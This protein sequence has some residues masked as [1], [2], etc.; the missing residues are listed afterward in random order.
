MDNEMKDLA[1]RMAADEANKG[2]YAAAAELTDFAEGRSYVGSN[3][4]LYRGDP[5]APTGPLTPGQVPCRV[6]GLD[7]RTRAATDPDDMLCTVCRANEPLRR[8]KQF[9]DALGAAAE[10]F[11]GVE[12][13]TPL[14]ETAEGSAE[15]DLRRERVDTLMRLADLVEGHPL[16]YSLVHAAET[17]FRH[18]LVP[19][20]IV[21]QWGIADRPTPDGVQ[22]GVDGPVG[23]PLRLVVES[24]ELR[25]RQ[26][27]SGVIGEPGPE[28]QMS[29]VPGHTTTVQH[30]LD[31]ALARIRE[32]EANERIRKFVAKSLDRLKPQLARRIA[33]VIC[34]PLEVSEDEVRGWSRLQID[35]WGAIQRAARE[36]AER[37][38]EKGLRFVP[39]DEEIELAAK[40]LR[41]IVAC[42]DDQSFLQE[43]D[44]SLCDRADDPELQGDLDDVRKQLNSFGRRLTGGATD[45]ANW[46]VF[47][48]VRVPDETVFGKPEADHG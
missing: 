40:H 45:P 42:T 33:A 47:G 34:P 22:F 18:V 46:G 31:S 26:D 5:D 32:L 6:C 12:P 7:D 48:L 39:T 38:V 36:A 20:Q 25:L 28:L 4:L 16:P 14:E 41:F 8:R 1:A 30:E 15:L 13:N 44:G 9:R 3:G 21:R 23:F 2:N 43:W 17:D 24:D 10:K 27:Q 37:L 19:G 35:E 11:F 29:E